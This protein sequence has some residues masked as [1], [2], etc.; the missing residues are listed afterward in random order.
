MTRPAATPGLFAPGAFAAA[1]ALS[2]LADYISAS[3]ASLA[4][5]VFARS[6][7]K[8]SSTWLRQTFPHAQVVDLLLPDL[9]SLGRISGD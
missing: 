8:S 3:C 9:V 4:M 5:R 6:D 1:L 2:R 7:A